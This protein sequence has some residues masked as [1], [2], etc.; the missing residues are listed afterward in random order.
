VIVGAA[1]AGAK[2]A[3]ALREEGFDGRVVLIGSEPEL[4]YERPPLSK[5]YLRGEAPREKARVHDDGFYESHDIELRTSTT[6]TAVDT[7]ASEVELEG[8][9][10]LRYDRL[11]LATGAEPRRLNIP[12]SD[13]DGVH[14]LRDLHDAD[15]LAALLAKGSGRVAVIGAGWIG[16]EVAASARTKGLEVALV[17]VADVPLER[18]LGR[19][20]GE[21]YADVHRNHGV[22]LHLGTGVEALEGAGRVE[23]V[24]LV[25]GTA[26]ECDFAVV[27]IGVVP[28]TQLAEQAGL[29]VGNGIQVSKRLET[30]ASGVFAAGDVANAFHP[31]YGTKVRV[32]HWANALNQP[33]TAAQAM[34]GRE[35]VS[36]DRLPYFFSDQYDVGMEYVGYATEWDE[37][38]I[39]G[40]ASAPEFV[41]F[42]LK[43]GAVQA[44]MNV[45]VWDVVEPIKALIASRQRVDVERLRDP[46]V[47]IDELAAAAAG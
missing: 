16:S 34:L 45:N 1:L 47:P 30:S 10:R 17:E 5:E 42:W 3:E 31:F 8:G 2:A 20:V 40:D 22:D 18:V 41:A 28:R 38:V 27:G 14:Y 35:G 23:R 9:E 4:P 7:R 6:V 43:D 12:G 29:E 15:A 25:D 13:L 46:D 32:E 11:L 24:K 26:I 19:Q 39:R 44:G 37:V 21:I 33:V 36:Y